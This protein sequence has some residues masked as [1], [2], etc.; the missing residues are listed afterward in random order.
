MYRKDTIVDEVLDEHVPQF[1][2]FGF[3]G[4]ADACSHTFAGRAVRVHLEIDFVGKNSP[5]KFLRCSA[6]VAPVPMA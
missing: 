3:F 5:R 2:V 4:D 6:S 1:N